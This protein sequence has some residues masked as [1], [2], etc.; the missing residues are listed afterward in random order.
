MKYLIIFLSF[1]FSFNLFA[2]DTENRFESELKYLEYE[3]LTTDEVKL[4]NSAIQKQQLPDDAK[5]NKTEEINEENLFFKSKEIKPRRI[6][7]R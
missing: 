5:E 6:R 4:S 7:S 3:A 1:A 2:D